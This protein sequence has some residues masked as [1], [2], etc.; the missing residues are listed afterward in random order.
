MPDPAIAHAEAIHVTPTSGTA[1]A[2]ANKLEETST[3]TMDG[4]HT[5]VDRQNLNSDGHTKRSVTWHA[6]SGTLEG[7]C[8]RGSTV[9]ATL[10]TA[11]REGTSVF[12]SVIDDATAGTGEHKGW[13]YEAVLGSD[14]YSWNAGELVGLTYNF[15]VSGA[16]VEILGT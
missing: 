6:Y 12:F 7:R 9:Q 14:G 16:P 11:A 4:E 5:V 2:D 1:L 10:E 8:V 13:R 3:F 15:S